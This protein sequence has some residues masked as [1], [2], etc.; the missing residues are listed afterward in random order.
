ML[1]F[2]DCKVEIYHFCENPME[3]N[4]TLLFHVPLAR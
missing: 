2:C 3:N 1:H 4:L